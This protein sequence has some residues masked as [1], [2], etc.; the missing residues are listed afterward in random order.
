M[1]RQKELMEGRNQGMEYALRIVETGGI[2]ALKREIKNRGI[3]GISLNVTHEELDRA[4]ERIKNQILD[5]VLTMSLMV[6]RDEFGFGHERLNRFKERFNFKT[7][8]L[9]D[10]YT[11]WAEQLDILRD[12]A[13]LELD[14]RENR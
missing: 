2:E 8:C 5:T 3:T 7:E 10:G 9:V 12:E 4:S 13:K 11:T 6:L 14:I 1:G